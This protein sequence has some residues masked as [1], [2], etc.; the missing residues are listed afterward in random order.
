MGIDP[1]ISLS[2][3]YSELRF[4]LVRVDTHTYVN[5]HAPSSVSLLLEICD[6]LYVI[7]NLP[8]NCSGKI[9]FGEE[10]Y[11][12]HNLFLLKMYLPP[13]SAVLVDTVS[14]HRM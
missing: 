7:R 5:A 3:G 4:L 10:L 8:C 2:G 1:K 11:Y 14:R 6:C 9:T 12:L 13:S